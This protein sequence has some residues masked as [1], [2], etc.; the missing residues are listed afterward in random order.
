MRTILLGAQ[1]TKWSAKER[2][3]EKDII[4]GVY[5]WVYAFDGDYCPTYEATPELLN[6][7]DLVIANTDNNLIGELVSL[8]KRRDKRVKWCTLIERCATDYLSLR[9]D[10]LELF[11]GSDLVNVINKHSLEFF[12]A[13]TSAKCEYIGIPY[14]AEG[15]RNAVPRLNDLPNEPKDIFL[16][17]LIYYTPAFDTPRMSYASLVAAAEGIKRAGAQDEV[18]VHLIEPESNITSYDRTRTEEMFGVNVVFHKEMYLRDY[19]HLLNAT[20]KVSVGLDHRYTWGRHVL[21]CAT[22]GIPLVTTESTGHGEYANESINVLPNEFNIH[23]AAYIVQK[24]LRSPAYR[25]GYSDD[26]FAELTHECMRNRLVN[27]L[28]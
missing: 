3:Y 11:N 6:S 17:P 4:S 12:Q 10:I 8:Q 13:I 9:K 19:L 27:A 15:V 22:L 1:P 26:Y 28:I 23:R 21:D 18:S 7:Y 20:A 2:L 25:V 24:Q 14:P 5:A 16:M